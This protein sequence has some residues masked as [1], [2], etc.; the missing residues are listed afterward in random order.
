MKILV[1]EDETAMATLLKRGLTEEGFAVDVA[2]NAADAQEAVR[3]YEQDLI[4]LDVMLP[5]KD[6]FALC[7]AWRDEGITTPDSISD[8]AR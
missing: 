5:G 2:V 1:V 4:L 6:G 7:R 3:V 8:G